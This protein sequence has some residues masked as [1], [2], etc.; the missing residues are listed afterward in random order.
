MSRPEPEQREE[1][2]RE[3]HVALASPNSAPALRSVGPG[4]V[5]GA[6]IN[7][8]TGAP[9]PL[10][11]LGPIVH[12]ASVACPLSVA[13]CPLS[14]ARGNVAKTQRGALRRAADVVESQ[15][16]LRVSLLLHRPRI[17]SSGRVRSLGSASPV[18]RRLAALERAPLWRAPAARDGHDGGIRRSLPQ[19][20]RR[21]RAR[22]RRRFLEQK[23]GRHHHGSAP[24]SQ[25]LGVEH[26]RKSPPWAAVLR[27]RQALRQPWRTVDFR[28]L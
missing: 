6:G 8:E 16:D 3:R 27:P 4:V 25:A 21:P 1:V 15:H 7:A 23:T 28:Q 26:R 12:G 14:S 2:S 11:L 10:D 24:P 17:R 5:C 13:K 18:A 20:W 9:L 22:A 19:G